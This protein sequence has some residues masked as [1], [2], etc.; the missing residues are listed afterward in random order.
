MGNIE[1]LLVVSKISF[2]GFLI[3]YPISEEI[4]EWFLGS[5]GYKPSNVEIIIL[6]PMEVVLLQ[7][8]KDM[9]IKQFDV[10]QVNKD[11]INIVTNS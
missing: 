1:N 5:E 7:L 2:V 4:I 11:I 6:Q 9:V 8:Q 3:G 10:K